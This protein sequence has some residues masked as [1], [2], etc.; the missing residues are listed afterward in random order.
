MQVEGELISNQLKGSFF[1][2]LS[3]FGEAFSTSTGDGTLNQLFAFEGSSQ[4]LLIKCFG[5][6]GFVQLYFIERLNAFIGH[7]YEK[8]E[9]HHYKKE[10]TILLN[11][12]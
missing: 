12:R 4:A 3:Q 2:K 5:G 11:K 10:G 1:M 7:Y 8:G 9:K 6:K